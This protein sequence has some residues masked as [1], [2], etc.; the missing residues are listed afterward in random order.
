[1]RQDTK[2]GARDQRAYDPRWHPD[3]AKFA[4]NLA[5]PGN[6]PKI[7]AH[8]ERLYDAWGDQK[9]SRLTFDNRLDAFRK[10]ERDPRCREDFAPLFIDSQIVEIAEL[11][12]YARPQ[13]I[14]WLKPVYNE[15]IR[16][17]RRTKSDRQALLNVQ[18]AP[19]L[20][21]C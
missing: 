11:L 20:D 12:K 2:S 4:R 18:P 7:R 13:T 5:E 21:F 1:M 16:I 6:V 10:Y 19:S 15:L 17:A 14:S 8:A 9:L 3:T